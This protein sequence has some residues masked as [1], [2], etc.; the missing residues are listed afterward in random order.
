MA[1]TVLAPALPIQPP[2]KSKKRRSRERRKAERALQ[3]SSSPVWTDVEEAFF[4]AAP[5]DE[6][7]PAAAA[8]SFEDLGGPG[9]P[10]QV[11]ASWLQS[12]LGALRT[13][14]RRRA[15]ETQS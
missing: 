15:P 6:P 3:R 9:P 1:G 12:L 7:E 2:S 13:A 11:R 4:A 8:E 5:P 14:F 10:V